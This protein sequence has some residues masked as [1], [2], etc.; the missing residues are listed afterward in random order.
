MK[1]LNPKGKTE[2]PSIVFAGIYLLMFV[3]VFMTFSNRGA[4]GSETG[5]TRGGVLILS[6]FLMIAFI[7]FNH[8]QLRNQPGMVKLLI[9]WTLWMSITCLHL[10]FYGPHASIKGLMEVLYCPLFFICFYIFIRIRPSLG[11]LMVAVFM[12]MLGFVSLLF[13]LVFRYQSSHLLTFAYRQ[14]NDVYYVLL[15]LPWVLL[16][17]KQFLRILGILLIT[18]VVFWSLKRTACIALIAAL[19]A[20]FSA[21]GFCSSRNKMTVRWVIASVIVIFGVFLLFNEIETRTG[22][23]LT[24]RFSSILEDEGSGRLDIY[25]GVIHA[26]RESSVIAWILGH[27]HDGVRREL[28]YRIR[29]ADGSHSLSAHNDW[30]EVLFDYGLPGLVLYGL[31]HM[32]I[33]R[34]THKLIWV[35]SRY[36][37]P[38]AASY[39]IFFIMSI[40][41]HLVLYPTY[42]SY[43]MAFWG[44]TCAV[45]EQEKLREIV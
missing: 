34:N 29:R 9:M 23:T 18:G 7:F 41:S 36:G 22:G 12:V 27:G 19:V 45:Q 35:R 13:V 25:D 16:C 24:G 21:E 10:F 17:R 39:A 5:Y 6:N 11:Q 28:V 15:L 38:M 44:M 43:L 32:G 30:L 3:Y 31:F 8:R 33:L 26:Q 2:K 20:Y 4:F 42:L 14:I 40:T 1:I 37:P